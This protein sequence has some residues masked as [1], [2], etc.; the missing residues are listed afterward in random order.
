M[1][2]ILSGAMDSIVMGSQFLVSLMLSTHNQT[3]SNASPPRDNMLPH[4]D[5]KSSFTSTFNH[6]SNASQTVDAYPS[7]FNKDLQFPEDIYSLVLWAF[8]WALLH[9]V[10]ARHV[11]KPLSFMIVPRPSGDSAS[12]SYQAEVLKAD[13]ERLKFQTASWRALLYSISAS[14][15][16]Y[17]C[18]KEDWV[19][20]SKLYFGGYPHTTS[21]A[22]KLYYNVGFGNYAYQLVNVFS[23]RRQSDFAQI[24][25]HHVATVIL[26]LL[27]YV[28]GFLRCGV[29]VLFLHD[30][31][32]PLM[33][34]A[35]CFVY[36]GQKKLADLFFGI[37]AVTFMVT[38]NYLFP[39]YIVFPLQANT[40][41]EDGVQMPRGYGH[42]FYPLF[43]CTYV[44]QALDVFWGYLIL[45]MVAKV[46][47]SGE[48]PKGDI[49]DEDE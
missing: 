43:V 18:L 24:V 15:G 28:M 45:K 4:T 12:D 29:M 5:F 26:M 41:Y 46:M 39:M 8:A 49:R 21:F 34:L 6:S 20:D 31:S 32:D 40:K 3:S 22:L 2:K 11:F 10:M 13:K 14:L 44:L 37:F 25:T 1:P 27:S 30:C 47:A 35:K 42:Y 38:R 36:A 48:T 23:E 17:I 16:I 33:E 7:P 19:W 9:A